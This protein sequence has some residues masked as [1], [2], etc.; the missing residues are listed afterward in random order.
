MQ[1]EGI[2]P[3]THRNKANVAKSWRC[4][5]VSGSGSFRQEVGR[6]AHFLPSRGAPPRLLELRC[7]CRRVRSPLENVG[8]TLNAFTSFAC[9]SAFVLLPPSGGDSFF[10]LSFFLC[11][12]SESS[13]IWG[14][15]ALRA[16]A[17]TSCKSDFRKF[18]TVRVKNV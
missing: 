5:P 11:L 15:L 2:T 17:V 4:S 3:L 9:L 12:F 7:S 1:F 14:Q 13:Q 8:V 16:I 6:C 10:S 18:Y